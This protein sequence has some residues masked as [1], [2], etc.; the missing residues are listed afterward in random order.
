MN[1]LFEI[2]DY[3]MQY[4]AVSQT[5]S[6]LGSMSQTG[7]ESNEEKVAQVPGFILRMQE[8]IAEKKRLKETEKLREDGKADEC[9]R[10]GDGTA[11]APKSTT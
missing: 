8:R 1:R 11:E 3:G 10:G 7:Q 6:V 4:R 5:A 9:L 2:A